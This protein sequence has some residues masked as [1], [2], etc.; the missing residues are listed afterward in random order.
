MGYEDLAQKLAGAGAEI[1]DEPHED[2]QYDHGEIANSIGREALQGAEE[3]T[4]DLMFDL[5]TSAQWAQWLTAPVERQ[6]RPRTKKA[7][8]GWGRGRGRTA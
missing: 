4:F 8:W 3:D 7:D 5:L 1:R 2:A 6:E